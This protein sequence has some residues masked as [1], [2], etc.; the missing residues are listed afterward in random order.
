[1]ANS[2]EIAVFFQPNV[3]RDGQ[4]PGDGIWLALP[5]ANGV[6]LLDKPLVFPDR[7]G[8]EAWAKSS[9]GFF[10]SAKYNS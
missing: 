2:V 9:V 4:L 6:A 8:A 3:D 7:K 5:I 1:M 10:V